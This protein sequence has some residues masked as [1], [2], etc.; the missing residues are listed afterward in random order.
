MKDNDLSLRE[1]TMP[2]NR[3]LSY[4]INSQSVATV[5]F[6]YCGHV[7]VVLRQAIVIG[8]DFGKYSTI[9]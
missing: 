3:F 4:E 1:V 5:A 6:R 2:Q 7:M 8:R 9:I